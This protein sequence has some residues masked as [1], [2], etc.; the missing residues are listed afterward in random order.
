[1]TCTEASFL[2][3]VAA[4]KMQIIRDDGVYRHIRFGEPGSSIAQFDLITWPGYL[5]FTGDMGSFVFSRL[6]D[7]FEFFRTD[8]RHPGRIGVNLSYWSE[9]LEAVDRHDGAWEF[10]EALF[11]R[12]VLEYLVTWLRERRSETTKEE[13]RELWESVV[14]DVIELDDDSSGSRRLPAVYDFSAN[15]NEAVGDF[16]FRDFWERNF[17]TY[18]TRYRWCCYAIAWGIQCYDAQRM[19]ASVTA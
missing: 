13:R 3:D 8:R 18:T 6:R 2:E 17:N 4:H 9:K 19:P 16:E 1:M 12:V 7:M 15:V 14:A 5:C 11:K 10:D